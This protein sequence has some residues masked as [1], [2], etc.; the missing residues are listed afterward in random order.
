MPRPVD[1]P[2]KP[3]EVPRQCWSEF[4][5]K[6]KKKFPSLAHAAA[7]RQEGYTSYLCGYCRTFHNGRPKKNHARDIARHENYVME[8][9]MRATAH[10]LA[11]DSYEKIVRNA[12]RARLRAYIASRKAS[13]PQRTL[14]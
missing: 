14:P 9:G 1:R 12:R 7:E 5:G 8:L 13:P 11:G 6:L 2:R 10:L 4:G 3:R